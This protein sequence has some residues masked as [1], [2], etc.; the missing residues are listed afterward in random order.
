MALRRFSSFILLLTLI[1]P[2]FFV[3]QGIQVGVNTSV[4]LDDRTLDLL[5]RLPKEV[6]EQIV[7]AVGDALPIL[8]KSVNA[9]LAKINEI[10][11]RQINHAQCSMTGVIAEVDRRAKIGREKGPLELFDE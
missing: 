8:D 11:D 1:F 9:Y 5:N 3:G 6:R 2:D 10:L 7:N 4:G